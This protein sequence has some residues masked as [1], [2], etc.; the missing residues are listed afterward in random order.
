MII[1]L[2]PEATEEQVQRIIQRIKE[3]GLEPDVSK[4]VKRT[5]IG[6][7]GEEDKIRLLPIEVMAGVEK[8]MPILAP[9]KRASREFRPEDTIV[10]IG[11][12]NVGGEEVA[13]AAGPCAVED[14][15]MLFATARS[16][17]EAGAVLLRG[18]AFKPRTSPY[19]FQGLGEEGLKL[20]KEASEEFGLP[21]VTEVMD[22]RQVAL[23]ARYADV[24]QIGAR[25]MQNF[26]LLTEVGK[27]EK[28]VVLKRGMAASIKELLMSAEYILNQ[29][30]NRVILC[31][32]G[33]KTFEDATRFTADISAIP[34]IKA[35]S[36][37]PVIFDPSHAA[38][39]WDLVSPLARAAV[40]AGADGLL[41]EVHSQPDKAL[42]DGP[43]ALLPN[44][45]VALMEDLREIAKVLGRRL[46]GEV[47][48]VSRK[49][50]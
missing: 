32:R 38:G 5:I 21:V 37:L 8:V 29:G 3:L 44:R 24:I 20:L 6:V 15:D 25:N 23:V 48:A 12:V 4:G 34:V 13:V 40:A 41:I 19:S 33:I 22:T 46:A 9:Y 42:S 30:H 1:V 7:I 36:H 49:R 27:T 18:G 35:L 26:P 11:Q 31:E 39:R 50:D 17:K 28:P 14:R 16:V 10:K 47:V 45:F 43:Q 2:K